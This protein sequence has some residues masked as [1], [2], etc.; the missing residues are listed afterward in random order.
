MPPYELSLYVQISIVSHYEQLLKPLSRVLGI[1]FK[2]DVEPARLSLIHR[3]FLIL[4]PDKRTQAAS[5]PSPRCSH[6]HLTRLPRHRSLAAPAFSLV[7]RQGLGSPLACLR[8]PVLPTAGFA[9]GDGGYDGTSGAGTR[10]AVLR[11]F[12]PHAASDFAVPPT[13]MDEAYEG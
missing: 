9:R 3:M 12:P 11:K 4:H 8:L 2:F 6:T 5:H 10:Y 7:H 1:F 13:P